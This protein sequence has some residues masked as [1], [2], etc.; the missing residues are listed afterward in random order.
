M[1]RKKEP[2]R[3]EINKGKI[4]NSAKVLFKTN[5]F[6]A[7]KMEEIAKAVDMSKTTLYVYF[8]NKDEI[9]NYLSLQAM[10]AF[11]QELCIIKRFQKETLYER[12]MQICDSLVDLKTNFPDE[13]D[14]IVENICVNQE[15]LKEDITLRSIY[16]KGEAV[17]QMLFSFFEDVLQKGQEGARVIFSQWGSIYGLIT[18]AFNKEEY[19]MQQ[20]KLTR[21]EFLRKGFEDLFV[22]F[23]ALV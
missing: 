12:Y 20:M 13:F 11:Y 3:I 21:A 15:I 1:A 8:K 18:L 10:E 9:R 16:E 7:T 6:E 22:S 2:E 14:I 4:A 5:G 19:I 23:K 17:N